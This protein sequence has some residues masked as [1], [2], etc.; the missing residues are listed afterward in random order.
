M[1]RFRYVAHALALS[2]ALVASRAG[3]EAPV[4]GGVKP[5]VARKEP[6]TTQLHGDTL[7]DDYYWLRNKG[8]AEVETH[9]KAELAYAQAFM[10][11]TA[12][13]QQ[14]LYDEMLSR[15]Q[16]T[17]TNVPYLDHGYFYY[18]RTEEGKQYPIYARKKGT[19]EA[20]EEILLDVNRLAEGKKFMAIG[21]MEVSP[22][23]N[24]LAYSVDETG[25][26]QYTLHV[27]D[28]R[29]GQLGPEAME[30]VTSVARAEDGRTL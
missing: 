11:P 10:K 13:L 5:P 30:R 21:D 19:L 28:L 7:V 22:D 8:T 1:V 4:T 14:K 15:I 29:T 3:A 12:A 18:S 17:D 9:L 16:Q 25:F 2:G 6:R 26:R 24:L 27:K 23:G 20:A